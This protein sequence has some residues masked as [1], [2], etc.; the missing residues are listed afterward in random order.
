MNLGAEYRGSLGPRSA[1]KKVSMPSHILVTCMRDASCWDAPAVMYSV[2]WPGGNAAAS[3]LLRLSAIEIG[4]LC[5]AGFSPPA[6]MSL[7]A[8][9]HLG[10]DQKPAAARSRAKKRQLGWYT[11][12][13]R[14]P[15]RMLCTVGTPVQWWI[16]PCD[17]GAGGLPSAP[18]HG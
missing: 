5:F 10:G 12:T 4:F 15:R 11:R 3:P 18:E 2:C 14:H 13:K 8:L 1:L 16:P 17:G 9:P 6:D 7:D